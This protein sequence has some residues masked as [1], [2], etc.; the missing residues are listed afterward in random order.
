MASA[1]LAHRNARYVDRNEKKLRTALLGAKVSS[2]P[3]PED[4]IWSN[5]QMTEKEQDPKRIVAGLLLFIAC[6]FFTLPVLV[7]SFLANLTTI[8]TFIP[9]LQTWQHN[10]LGT[11][12]AVSGIL[13]PIV[14]AIFAML[15]PIIIRAVSKLQG[16]VSFFF[17]SSM[18][19]SADQFLSLTR[20]YSTEYSNR[21]CKSCLCSIFRLSFRISTYPLLVDFRSLQ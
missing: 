16:I 12:S 14:S 15:I 20:K 5:I 2:A 1:P 19:Q 18:Y 11:F 7:I 3:C 10:S 8:S 9:F 13:P 21:A 4:I 6:A 17:F